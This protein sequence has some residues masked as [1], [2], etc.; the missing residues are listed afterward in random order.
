M[1]FVSFLLSSLKPIEWINSVILQ[2]SWSS[3]ITINIGAA[4]HD[5]VVCFSL[6]WKGSPFRKKYAM[7]LKLSCAAPT[8][9]K[10]NEIKFYVL[11]AHRCTNATKS[12][13]FNEQHSK[14]ELLLLYFIS[15]LSS[16]VMST[17]ALKLEHYSIKMLI[18]SVCIESCYS[19]SCF[20]TWFSVS[21][22]FALS[23][24]FD[25]SA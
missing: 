13:S 20:L 24:S 8:A 3:A 17:F 25:V 9:D 10:I 21:F 22:F 12:E 7:K 2:H 4:N 16:F 11:Q 19:I 6:N 23:S 15:E 14:P 1:N 5:Y 18:I